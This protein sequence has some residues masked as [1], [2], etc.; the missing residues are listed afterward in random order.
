MLGHELGELNEAYQT[1]QLEDL[2]KI[3]REVEP[4]LSVSLGEDLTKLKEIE[5]REREVQRIITTLV[6]E[7]LQLKER[8]KR[9]EDSIKE[10]Q[11]LKKALEEALGKKG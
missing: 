7:N 5:E 2:K 8:V 10:V 11:E 1:V 9:L 6:S 4:Y 3:Y